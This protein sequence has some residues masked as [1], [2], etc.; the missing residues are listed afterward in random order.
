MPVVANGTTTDVEEGATVTV[1][2]DDG[3][4]TLVAHP[5][6]VHRLICLGRM[7]LS[8]TADHRGRIRF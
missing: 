2:F 4:Q 3:N 1:T 6:L 5:A 8:T 7:G